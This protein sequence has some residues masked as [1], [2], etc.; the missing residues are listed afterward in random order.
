M[1][2][3]KVNHDA[4]IES[5]RTAKFAELSGAYECSICD[6]FVANIIGHDVH[7]RTNSNDQKRFKRACDNIGGAVIWEGES[8][9]HHTQAQGKLLCEYFDLHMDD[10]TMKYSVLF[11][12]CK[13]ATTKEEIE[14]I[15]WGNDELVTYP[16]V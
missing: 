2:I 1:S 14:A 11:Q 16:V 4:Q 3:I 5:A 15:T 10:K 12:S 8:A 7:Y 6:G 9:T 13:N